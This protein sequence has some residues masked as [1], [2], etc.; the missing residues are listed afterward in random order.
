MRINMRGKDLISKVHE[1][2]EGNMFKILDPEKFG[3]MIE[4][5]TGCELYIYDL[6][7][8][9]EREVIEE[10]RD[11]VEWKV[12]IESGIDQLVCGKRK[13][14]LELERAWIMIAM[15][16]RTYHYMII[17]DWGYI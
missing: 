6:E 2:I 14:N 12:T 1:L 8:P 13:I 16:D 11:G 7:P 5:E 10:E 4:K 17:F 3:E 15:K 9:V